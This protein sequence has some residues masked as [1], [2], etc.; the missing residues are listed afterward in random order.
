[1]SR[2]HG[3]I[4]GPSTFRG[5]YFAALSTRDDL[6]ALVSQSTIYSATWSSLQEIAVSRGISFFPDV[7]ALDIQTTIGAKSWPII[8]KLAHMLDIDIYL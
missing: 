5:E 4:N 1:M 3:F 6:T 7:T 8:R 2:Y